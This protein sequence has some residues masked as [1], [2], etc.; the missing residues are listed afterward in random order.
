M[1][2][3][4]EIASQFS[5]LTD[6]PEE[7]LLQCIETPKN[8][9]MA[10]LA[11]PVPKLNR[12]KKLP[13]NPAQ[14]AT[15]YAAKFVLNDLIK[16]V[17]VAGTYINFKINRTI[18]TESILK[19]VLAAGDKYGCTK[20]GEGKTIVIEFSSPNI[21]KPFHAGHLRSTIIGNFLVNV[22]R[23]L[24]Y[25]VQSINYLGDWGKQYG[26]LAIGYDRFGSEQALL[27]DPIKHLFDVYVKINNTAETEPEIHD[28]A[29]AYFKDM[30]DGNE[31]ALKLW[32][33]FRDLSI[34]K[35]KEIYGRLNVQFDEYSGE[36][37]MCDGMVSAYEKL[38]KLGLVEDSKGAKIIDLSTA[39][40]DLGKVL[41]KKTDGSSLY[42]TRDIAAAS[43]RKEQYNFEK[44]IYVV[45]SQQELHFRQL[46]KILE[47]MQ[48]PWSKELT[49]IGY[50]LVKGMSTRKGT[51]VFL[52]E[53]LNESKSIMLETMKK[54]EQKFAEI[55][56]PDEVA[57]IVAVSA[58]I[59]QDFSAKRNKDYDF[60]WER[61]LSFEGDTGPYLQYA[62]ARLCSIERKTGVSLNPSA[63][64]SLLV[65]PI[66]YNLA[67]II[68]RYP[69]IVQIAFNN[70][71]PNTIVTY[72][73]ELCHEIS[74][75][76][77]ALKV[78]GSEQS[79]AEARYVLFYCAK[80]VLCNGLRL[81]GL[82]PLERM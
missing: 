44:M 48:Y 8:K 17:T 60:N 57:D 64:L 76:H 72:L 61:M 67:T 16:E 12:F 62:H 33:K 37:K 42:I 21:A 10:D 31:N 38:D 82:R 68:Q 14:L 11:L 6:I 65:E 52:E 23:S 79:L 70:N 73:F 3:E 2:F 50:G 36:S 35:Y 4:K 9:D 75:A 43:I 71:E 39:K 41:V 46:F 15:E 58:V 13:G 28:Q 40:P 74:A 49:H 25:T 55:E 54:N 19:E 18:L 53:I 45:A 5:K 63:N 47:R 59:I 27:E 66:A 22:Y 32:S 34:E 51:V 1:L 24:G 29:R 77:S 80:L 78:K 81:L 30:E 69:E 56:N 7:Q 20:Q 26:L